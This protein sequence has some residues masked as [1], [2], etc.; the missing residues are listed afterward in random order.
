MQNEK[1]VVFAIP[2]T[3]VEKSMVDFKVLDVYNRRVFI[4]S[5]PISDIHYDLI[6]V[7]SL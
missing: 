4:V 1:L 6:I 7:V 3:E 5:Y 2:N